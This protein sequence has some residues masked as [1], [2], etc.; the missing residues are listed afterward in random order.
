MF[1]VELV[2]ELTPKLSKFQQTA[3]IDKSSSTH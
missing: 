1:V 2:V 3:T